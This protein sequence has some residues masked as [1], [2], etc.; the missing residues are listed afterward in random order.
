M[1]NVFARE[2][3][4]KLNKEIFAYQFIYRNGLSGSFPLDFS[5]LGNNED[6]QVGLSIDELMQVN[7]TVINLLP[8]G[9]SEFGDIFS[10]AD[11]M[12]E[13]S[14]INTHPNPQLLA[15]ISDLKAKGFKL[16]ANQHQL[17]WSEFMAKMDFVKLNIMD[18]TPA[19]IAQYKERFAKTNIKFI[20]TNV[21]SKFQFDQCQ[22]I[23][24]DYLQG[25]F[26]LEREKLNTQSLPTNKMAYMQLMATISKPEL[27]ILALEAIFHQDP[28]LS[29][30][31]IKFINNPLI[32]KSHKISS[33]RHAL[34]YLGELKVRR[35]V[36]IISL[37]GLNA[38]KPSEL[39]NL[40][41][42]RA[43][44]CELM[45]AELEGESNA[46]AAFLV[47]LFSL[48]DVI[49]CK[50]MKD[51][52]VSLELDERITQALID[53]E[54]VYWTIL[55]SIKSIE[56]GDWKSLFIYSLELVMSKDHMFDIHR[57][58]VRWQN[59]MTSAIS[60]H[61]PVAKPRDGD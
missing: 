1:I 41:L 18:N 51:L 27:D 45:D 38:D 34:N 43:K 36:A 35:F 20:A 57:Q 47:G 40:S 15:Q 46:M 23:G 55:A 60:P 53:N 3:I 4:F 8:E 58:S 30:L 10:P 44:Y 25:F 16:V 11:V 31:L 19:E 39:L 37:A 17:K 21:H 6:P 48:I 42:S 14:E 59:Q 29:F 26:F 24:V 13:I 5:N 54:G 50:E 28:A 12:I 49:L 61:F 33:I 22:N 32:N 9:L 2:P 7:L 52:I 56:S